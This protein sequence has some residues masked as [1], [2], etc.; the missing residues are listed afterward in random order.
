MGPFPAFSRNKCFRRSREMVC[1]RLMKAPK[2]PTTTP[3]TWVL[4]ITTAVIVPMLFLLLVEGLLRLIGYGYPTN[5]FLPASGQDAV[6]ANPRY[7]YRYFPKNLVREP[8]L[9]RMNRKKPAGAYRIFILGGSAAGGIPELRFGFGRILEVMLEA[10]YPD[11]RFEVVNTAMVAINSHTVLR[12]AK[13]CAAYEPDLF[14][15]Y[16]GNN[17]VVGPFGAGTILTRRVPGRGTVALSLAARSLR[18]GQLIGNLVQGLGK[19]SAPPEWLGMQ[20][21]L[22]HRVPAGDPRMRKVYDHFEGNLKDLAGTARAAG[23]PLLL[24]TVPVNLRNCAPLASDHSSDL[25]DGMR[26]E[27]EKQYRAGVAQE[28]KSRWAEAD[29]YYAQAEK[30]DELYAELHFRRARCALARGDLNAARERFETARDLDTL[31][32]RADSK[33][34]GMIRKAGAADSVSLVDVEEQFNR[35][36]RVR[37]GIPGDHLFYEHVHFTFEGNY[38][39][40][41]LV[42]DETVNRLDGAPAAAPSQQRCA[43]LLGFSGRDR[44][45]MASSMMNLVVHAPFTGQMDYYERCEKLHARVR[46]LRGHTTGK[47]FGEAE[48]MLTAAL[49]SRP[50]VMHRRLAL[51]RL[52]LLQRN[53]A[54]A[55][56][57]LRELLRRLPD[58]AD[59]HSLLGQALLI[60]GRA[61]EAGEAFEKSIALAA[62]PTEYMI[63]AA[64][65]YEQQAGDLDR[66]EA[67]CRRAIKKQPGAATRHSR[68]AEIHLK[69][70]QTEQALELLKYAEALLPGN[71]GILFNLARA[72][73]E[74]GNRDTAALKLGATLRAI[75]F[76]LGARMQL[77]LILKELGRLEEAAVQLS[78]V[79]RQEPGQLVLR[80][81]LAETRIGLGRFDEAES[82]YRKILGS[83]PDRLEAVLGLAWVLAVRP[84]ATPEV[85][86]E[87]APLAERVVK[88]TGRK[89]AMPL[90]VLAAAW[91]AAEQFDKAR[92]CA[93]E[94]LRIALD[95]QHRELAATVSGRLDLYRKNKPYRLPGR[96]DIK[97]DLKK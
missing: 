70:G 86:A 18:T 54:A 72:H 6:T 68:L 39:L 77:G 90:D 69:R 8:D 15:L 84:D 57:T 93:E 96:E 25:D 47:S 38:E 2:K 14:V 34:N 32:F 28:A 30:L 64:N 17:E 37:H 24:C 74:T 78:E 63:R 66:A 27:W 46:S 60:R 41:R 16:M 9:I 92:A 43:E 62:N 91:A 67:F 95:G 75:P 33:I 35:L 7:T 61:E 44:F 83:A 5:F 11:R 53:G 48:R 52:Q 45:Q 87:A 79:A 13:E 23:I 76:H 26:A 71:G 80:L 49:A 21:F 81:L 73:Y 82:D 31:R 29:E 85:R 19:K 22:E 88:A 40:A 36:P 55:E 51:A 89:D 65:V 3:R 50:D 42:F 97:V 59:L 58:Q 20:M 4:R 94:A 1:S 56:T 10:A 12:I